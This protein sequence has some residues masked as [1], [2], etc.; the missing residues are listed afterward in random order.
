MFVYDLNKQKQKYN[1]GSV[2]TIGTVS[3]IFHFRLEKQ[4][5]G[6][7]KLAFDPCII[8]SL[9]L[10]IHDTFRRPPFAV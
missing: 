9:P 3:I 2:N 6:K 4:I 1:K 8:R 7:K 10:N 5:C